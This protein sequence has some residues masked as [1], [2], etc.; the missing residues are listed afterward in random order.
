M[1]SF[2]EQLALINGQL[3]EDQKRRN[4]LRLVD[5]SKKVTEAKF[6]SLAAEHEPI[7]ERD[8]KFYVGREVFVSYLH[9]ALFLK[10]QSVYSC[11]PNH[12]KNI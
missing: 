8:G 10:Q 2:H 3:A 11:Y 9:A 12:A 5:N 7:S 6:A 1:P 4:H